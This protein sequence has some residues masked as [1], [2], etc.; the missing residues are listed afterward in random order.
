MS[1][2]TNY[3]RIRRVFRNYE[4]WIH[5][6]CSVLQHPIQGLRILTRGCLFAKRIN[7]QAS[8]FSESHSTDNSL[9]KA[10]PTSREAFSV[11]LTISAVW[12]FVL[13]HSPFTKVSYT[14]YCLSRTSVSVMPPMMRSFSTSSLI[15]WLGQHP[16]RAKSDT[17][18]TIFR[19]LMWKT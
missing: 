8:T 7:S 11:S 17:N 3:S 6:L 2:F 5:S 12:A 13:M 1:R 16:L 4:P 14:C 18:V 10:M 15:T 19:G 9:A